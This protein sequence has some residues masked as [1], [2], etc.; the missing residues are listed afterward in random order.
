M[1]LQRINSLAERV[2]RLLIVMA[3]V[4]LVV[5]VAIVI[6]NV[7]SRYVLHVSLTWSAELA[8]YAMVWSA[9]LAAAVLV[10]RQQHLS[11]DILQRY[12]RGRLQVA[13]QVIT[14][15]GSMTFFL[16]LLVSGCFEAPEPEPLPER[17]RFRLMENIG[18]LHHPIS[19]DSDVCFR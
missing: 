5:T 1:N 16:I 7:V 10:N 19:T 3:V 11:V 6:A 13:A 4:F 12:L 14:S 17:E 2:N 8:R 9:L 15:I 18:D